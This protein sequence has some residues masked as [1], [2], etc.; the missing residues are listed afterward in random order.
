M[1]MKEIDSL[2]NNKQLNKAEFELSKLHNK[3]KN[4]SE[5]L[6]LRSRIFY[7]K[8]LYYIAVD[9]LLISLEFAQDDKIYSFLGEIYKVLDQGELSNKILDKNLRIA[10][11]NDLKDTMT[12]LYRKK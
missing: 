9:T 2:I 5:Y 12:G 4:D 7:L 3:Y 8:K 11:V 1:E 10:T 6:F